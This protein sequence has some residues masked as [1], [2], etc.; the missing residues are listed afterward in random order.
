MANIPLYPHDP[1]LFSPVWTTCL[2]SSIN[3]AGERQ[4]SC[5]SPA[6]LEMRS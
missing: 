2:H 3:G 6:P 1:D 4:E 5:D